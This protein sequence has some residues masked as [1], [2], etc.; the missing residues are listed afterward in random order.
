MPQNELGN[1]KFWFWGWGLGPGICILAVLRQM[2]I[3]GESCPKSHYSGYSTIRCIR[4]NLRTQRE[5]MLLYPDS[6]PYR[7]KNIPHSK[8]EKS[9]N[10]ISHRLRILQAAFEKA[11]SS[12]NFLIPSSIIQEMTCV[13]V[14]EIDKLWSLAKLRE[15]I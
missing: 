6:K 7:M 1:L 2:S 15:P 9:W 11:S 14:S 5:E 10:Y 4:N 8:N 12:W 3:L 13:C